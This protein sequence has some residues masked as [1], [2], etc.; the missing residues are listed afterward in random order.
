M[1]PRFAVDSDPAELAAAYGRDGVLVVEDAIP[2]ADCDAL[3]ERAHAIVDAWDPAEGRSV[4]S[5]TAPRHASDAYFR[6]SGDKI[7]VFLEDGAV[8]AEGALTVDRHRAVNKLGHAM[9]DLD[10]DFDRV[11]RRPVLARI[12][13]TLGIGAPKLVQSM[14]IWKPPAIGGAVVPHQDAAFLVTDPPSVTGFWLA[15]EDADEG[16]GCLIAQ[17][18]GHKGPLRQRFLDRDGGLSLETLDATPY[19]ADGF[20]P[21][22]A[23]KGTLVVLHGL[24]PHGSAANT[25]PRSRMA[26][27]LH[28]VDGA[29]AWHPGN[30]IRRRPDDPFRGF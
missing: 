2:S 6:E 25:S 26:Y 24:L 27:T 4:F 17:P 14:V 3:I 10:P 19:P 1:I 18:G 20:V 7:R 5:T 12:A 21:L 16:N 30:W 23:R 15:L 22:P 8:D 28:M 11:S 13:A 29:A 9:H